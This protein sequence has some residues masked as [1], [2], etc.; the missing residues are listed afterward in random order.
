M[1]LKEL[2]QRSLMDAMVQNKLDDMVRKWAVSQGERQGLHAS[3][4]IASD[5]EFCFREHVLSFFYVR[6][7][8]TISTATLRK[9]LNGWYVHM[10]WQMLFHVAGV[11]D[12]T[13]AVRKSDLWNVYCTPDAIIKLLN[14]RFVVEIKSMNTFDYG[15]LKKPPLQA[16]KQANFY[17]FQTG[18]PQAIV[19]VEDKN[20]QDFMPWVIQF[21]VDLVRPYVERLYVLKRCV[22]KFTMKGKL[23]M[24]ICDASTNGRAQKCAYHVVCFASREER[25]H[26]RL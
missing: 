14:K 2:L 25:E 22:S 24:R 7:P 20:N 1:S 16:V 15:K 19:L 5:N 21:D 23:P 18:I 11:S 17:M 9:W 13:E 12:L 8:V 26:Y 6:N 3:S 10:K 4:I